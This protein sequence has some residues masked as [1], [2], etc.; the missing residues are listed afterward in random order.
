MN[1]DPASMHNVLLEIKLN[2]TNHAT[3]N[4]NPGTWP[5]SAA[6]QETGIFPL[7]FHL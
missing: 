3:E 2:F 6:W 1:L 5:E 4:P 7:D